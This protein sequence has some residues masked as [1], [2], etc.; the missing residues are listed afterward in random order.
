MNRDI[1][2]RVAEAIVIMN[3]AAKNLRL[4]PPSSAMIVNTIDKL[5]EAFMDIFAQETSLDFAEAEKKLLVCGEPLPPKEQ[6][7]PQL[8]PW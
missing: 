2:P 5:Q 3:T 7:R 4:Y 6:D 8:S 1:Q